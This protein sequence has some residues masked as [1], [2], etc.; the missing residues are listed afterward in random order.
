MEVAVRT[1]S[2][3]HFQE[4]G[5]F[6]LADADGGWHVVDFADPE[7]AALVERLL[8]LPGFDRERLAE[9]VLSRDEQVVTLW[10]RP[11]VPEPAPIVEAP[12][13]TP[14]V[15]AQRVSTTDPVGAPGRPPCPTHSGAGL[16]TGRPARAASSRR[17]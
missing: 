3:G 5:S 1:S 9:L 16:A 17:S 15:P 2:D 4:Y 10:R 12:V 8:Q 13:A 7:S 14:V 6:L 11:V